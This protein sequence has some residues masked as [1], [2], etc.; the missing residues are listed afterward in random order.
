MIFEPLAI[1]GA[2]RLRGEP[3]GDERGH[4]ARTFCEL[5]FASNGLATHFPQRSTSFNLRSGTVRGLHFQAAPHGETKIVRCTRGRVFDVIVDLRPNSPTFRAWHGEELGPERVLALYI[6]DG[7]AHGFQTLEDNSE[8]Y[9]EI[10]P[11][12]VASASRGVRY[13]DPE[14]AIAWPRSCAV[15]GERDRRLPLLSEIC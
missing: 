10:T 12:Y 5:E 1:A 9:Y 14:I 2:F 15:I 4:F 3:I 13:D 11:P 6:P 7:C 8:V